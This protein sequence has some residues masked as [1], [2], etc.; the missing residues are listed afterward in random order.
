[1]GSFSGTWGSWAPAGEKEKNQLGGEFSRRRPAYLP[2]LKN[3][4]RADEMLSLAHEY[5][6]G[7]S[8]R[9]NR[10][11][12]LAGFSLDPPVV[13]VDEGQLGHHDLLV[14]H[15]QLRLHG[16]QQICLAPASQGIIQFIVWIFE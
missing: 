12:D 5:R 7:G 1:M 3:T 8:L 15:V 13:D 4:A 14:G 16:D 11:L 2:C 10:T 6:G 9:T